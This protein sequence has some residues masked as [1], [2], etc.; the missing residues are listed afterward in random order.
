MEVV[1]E[2]KL[3][4]LGIQDLV[5]GHVVH[6]LLLLEVGPVAP[7]RNLL[8]CE[9]VGRLIGEHD[10]TCGEE[11]QADGKGLGG[12]DDL[13]FWIGFLCLE[14]DGHRLLLVNLVV[15]DEDGLILLFGEVVQHHSRL[16]VVL[17][18]D[19]GCVISPST[20]DFLGDF[21]GMLQSFFSATRGIVLPIVL[22]LLNGELDLALLGHDFLHGQEVHLLW[23]QLLCE[24]LLLSLVANRSRRSKNFFES[25]DSLSASRLS[26]GF[27]GVVLIDDSKAFSKHSFVKL[28]EFFM[29]AQVDA[30]LVFDGDIFWV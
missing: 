25:L 13:D 21:F 24:L 2:A 10:A 27:E 12:D 26:D 5:G 6:L 23:R 15:E 18:E 19:D 29:G 30:R 1:C 28:P 3:E 22:K 7:A 17:H 8:E 11:V 4:C 9:D 14:Q 16:F 20:Y